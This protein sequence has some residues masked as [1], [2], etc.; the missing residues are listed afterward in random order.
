VLLSDAKNEINMTRV[1]DE[2]MNYVT[3]CI[4]KFRLRIYHNQS[5]TGSINNNTNTNN[6]SNNNNSNNNNNNT[7]NNLK[8]LLDYDETE[9]YKKIEKT[10][11]DTITINNPVLL[12]FSKRLYKVLF[13]LFVGQPYL[14]KLTSFSLNIKG[15]E[16]N[17]QI[18]IE[19]TSTLFNH[20]FAIY[21][22]MYY[23]IIHSCCEFILSEENETNNKSNNNDNA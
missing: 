17:I 20:T 4:N 22:K 21:S 10:L 9:L 16:R 1:V 6:N 3:F 19:K 2:V 5:T 18:L 23:A 13:R 7:S 14:Q 8:N 15:Q 12:L 11:Q